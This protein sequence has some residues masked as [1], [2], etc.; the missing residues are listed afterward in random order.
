MTLPRPLRLLLLLGTPLVT[1]SLEFFHPTFLT[2]ASAQWWVTL[3]VLQLPLFGLLGL[4][5]YVLA[6]DTDGWWRV[7]G[8]LAAGVFAVFYGA[9][10]S[11]V[12]ISTGSVQV[13]KP[14]LDPAL[15]DGAE[16]AIQILFHGVGNHLIAETG[17]YAWLVGVVVIAAGLARAGRARTPLVLLVAGAASF[18]YTHEVPS[19][20]I[21]MYLCFL[22]LVWLECGPRRRPVVKTA[23]AIPERETIA[24]R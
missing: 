10:D 8:R 17:R 22:A 23:E 21:G 15:R 7:V 5:L 11:I 6:G 20:F 18:W 24:A 13:A 12:G 1:G 14:T 9:F 19:G 16:A 2:A 4:G 3:H